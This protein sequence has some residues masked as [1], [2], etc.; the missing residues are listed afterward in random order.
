ML[1]G[2]HEPDPATSYEGYDRAAGALASAAVG[3]LVLQE[4]SQQQEQGHSVPVGVVDG[5]LLGMLAAQQ[6]QQQPEVLA[7]TALQHSLWQQAL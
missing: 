6:Q 5:D 4:P 3:R 7:A 1:R 2:L